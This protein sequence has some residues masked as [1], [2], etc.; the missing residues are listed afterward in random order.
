MALGQNQKRPALFVYLDNAVVVI[1]G[2]DSERRLQRRAAA[3]GCHQQAGQHAAAHAVGRSR[4][5]RRPLRSAAETRVSKMLPPQ[6]PDRYRQGDGGT[7]TGGTAVL[8]AEKQSALH[9]SSYAGQPESSREHPRGQLDRLSG[10]PASPSD[11]GVRTWNHDR[12]AAAVD[13]IDGWW[14]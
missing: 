13:R 9:A 14:S 3:V 5:E 12:R 7:Q 6:I 10:R 8:D 2:T 1:D 4:T 11:L